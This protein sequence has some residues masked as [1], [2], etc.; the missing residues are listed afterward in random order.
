MFSSYLVAPRFHKNQTI[1]QFIIAE[2]KCPLKP[3]SKAITATHQFH[4]FS[5]DATI[6][7]HDISQG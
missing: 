6:I 5:I 7:S 1:A 3:L 4:A 2:T